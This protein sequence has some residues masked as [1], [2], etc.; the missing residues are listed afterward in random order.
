MHARRV[1]GSTVQ[2]RGGRKGGGVQSHHG[3]KKTLSTSPKHQ[4]Q[5]R[6]TTARHIELLLQV[7]THT[8]PTVR[9]RLCRTVTHTASHQICPTTTTTTTSNSN[10]NCMIPFPPVLYYPSSSFHQG[11]G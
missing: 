2:L 10:S 7:N 9:L 8:P 1:E 4:H 11:G 5:Q 3:N 6:N